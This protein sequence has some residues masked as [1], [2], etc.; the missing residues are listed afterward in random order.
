MS[1]HLDDDMSMPLNLGDTHESPIFIDEPHEEVHQEYN[2]MSAKQDHLINPHNTISAVEHFS[3]SGQVCKSNYK[4]LIWILISSLLANLIP[5]T[6]ISGLSTAVPTSVAF[7]ASPLTRA[8][9]AVVIYSVLN[10]LV[11]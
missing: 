11:Q 3:S 5:D 8:I 2:L 6:I 7:I 9:T 10:F 1:T 4:I